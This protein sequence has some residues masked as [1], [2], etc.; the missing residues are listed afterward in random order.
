MRPS[1]HARSICTADPEETLRTSAARRGTSML[2][3]A[4]A[5]EPE[6]GDGTRVVPADTATARRRRPLCKGE[7]GLRGAYPKARASNTSRATPIASALANNNP[8]Q[9]CAIMFA[10]VTGSH[11]VRLIQDVLS[12]V[13]G[14]PPQ[15]RHEGGIDASE[16]KVL[17]LTW[18]ARLL[19][20]RRMSMPSEAAAR[21][22]TQPNGEQRCDPHG[23]RAIPQLPQFKFKFCL[24]AAAT[25]AAEM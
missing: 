12:G 1:S 19:C 25:V 22:L 21:C 24:P 14:I 15:T 23:Q 7:V 6:R 2:V 3:A 18:P 10:R 4:I 20:R 11:V 13:S 16:R 5:R 8:C 17:S 9:A